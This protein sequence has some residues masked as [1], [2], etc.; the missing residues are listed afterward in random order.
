MNALSPRK[1]NELPKP[2]LRPVIGPGGE[3]LVS[4]FHAPDAS[5]LKA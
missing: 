1:I 2:L 5:R 4:S 3:I